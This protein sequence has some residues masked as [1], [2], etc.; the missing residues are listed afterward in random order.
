MI[1]TKL[2]TND[3]ELAWD[4]FVAHNDTATF[5]HQIA[6]KKLV[7]KCY[8]FK[9]IYLMAKDGGEIKGILP[10]FMIKNIFL[11]IRLISVPFSTVGGVCAN[12]PIATHQLIK[13]AIELTQAL[14]CDYLELRHLYEENIR[15]LVTKSNYFTFQLQLSPD[16]ENVWRNLNKTNRKKIRRARNNNLHVILESKDFETFYRIYSQGQRNLGT[17]IQDYKWLK[18]L[19]FDFPDNHFIAMAE[20]NEKTVATL[21]WRR[22][23]NSISGVLAYSLEEHRHLYP[24]HL[25]LWEL[26]EKACRNGYE[27]YDFGRSVKSSGTYFFKTTWRP[28]NIKLNYQYYLNKSRNIPDTSQKNPKRQLFSKLWKRLPVSVAN[29]LGPRI[30][31][32]FP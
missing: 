27:W 11:G 7:E 29:T 26:I 15:N 2:S 3:D 10:L 24:Y 17:P 21:F 28:E 4:E 20:H 32:Y 5:F 12:S 6:W 25:I 18:N 23:K 13:K 19:F 16:P 1:I 30:R 9:P 8:K 14:G 31:K 22:F